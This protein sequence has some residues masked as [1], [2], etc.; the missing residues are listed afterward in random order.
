MNKPPPQTHEER[1]ARDI[2][3]CLALAQELNMKGTVNYLLIAASKL[4][5]ERMER[6]R[7]ANAGT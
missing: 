7:R 2:D 3:R 6:M 4:R 1:L 5:D